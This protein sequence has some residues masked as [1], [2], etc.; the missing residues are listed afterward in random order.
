MDYKWSLNNYN[1]AVFLKLLHWFFFGNN[2]LYSCFYC[3]QYIARIKSG[4]TRESEAK[5]DFSG[6]YQRLTG[7]IPEAQLKK[8]FSNPVF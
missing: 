4:N 1:I 6:S 7:K 2:I 5:R 3:Q 8:D